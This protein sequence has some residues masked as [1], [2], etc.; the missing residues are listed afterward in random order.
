MNRAKT[1]IL[2]SKLTQIGV[3]GLQAFNLN[4]KT[5][6]KKQ[7]VQKRQIFAKIALFALVSIS[8][9]QLHL[10]LSEISIT[11][12]RLD[13]IFSPTTTSAILMILSYISAAKILF[14][15][16]LNKVIGLPYLASATFSTK[17]LVNYLYAFVGGNLYQIVDTDELMKLIGP[18][19]AVN[20]SASNGIAIITNVSGC[21]LSTFLLFLLGLEYGAVFSLLIWSFNMILPSLASGFL[22]PML[23]DIL[24]VRIFK[25][26]KVYYPKLNEILKNVLNFLFQLVI[27]WSSTILSTVN[28]F[29]LP[30][31]VPKTDKKTNSSFH[32]MDSE[33]NS[34]MSDVSDTESDLDLSLQSNTSQRSK[35]SAW[36]STQILNKSMVS[37][38]PSVYSTKKQLSMRQ[39]HYAASTHSLNRTHMPI[40]Q[41]N[42]SFESAFQPNNHL[43]ETRS[44]IFNLN[45]RSAFAASSMSLRSNLDQQHQMNQSRLATNMTKSFTNLDCS[46]SQVNFGTESNLGKSLRCSSRNSMYD[47]PDDFESGITQLSISGIG[48]R[49][50][51]YQNKTRAF[52][53]SEMHLTKPILSPSRLN[54]NHLPSNQSSWLA[55]GFWNNSNSPQ[56]KCSMSPMKWHAEQAPSAIAK[57]N[58]VFPIISRTSSQSSG[59]ESMKNASVNNNS[60][61]NSLCGD[62]DINRTFSFCEPAMMA[63]TTKHLIKPQPQ[64]FMNMM[65]GSHFGSSSTFENNREVSCFTPTPSTVFSQKSMHSNPF[66]TLSLHQQLPL[67]PAPFSPGLTNN[68]TMTP[69]H[70]FF[71]P[72]TTNYSDFNKDFPLFQRQPPFQRGSLIKLDTSN[73]N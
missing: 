38:A 63:Q 62:V 7:N 51:D 24:T 20:S 21:F 64:K 67:S 14:A 71:A 25:S 23:F 18:V 31:N 34:D 10:G 54:D 13:S 52:G 58:E 66:D 69:N 12:A 11:K 6:T 26:L 41:H 3:K 50:S 42:R 16:M 40:N 35:R 2:G 22:E 65:N 27:L 49:R 19:E 59:F 17:A 5:K 48:K 68:Q 1:N 55:G 72:N 39:R 43:N 53:G 46:A 30:R 47:V 9:M 33:S 70:S 28:L 56:K 61:E 29:T 15:Q 44:D 37:N 60:R 73:E 32:R 36:N 57:S 8:A 4:D 45:K